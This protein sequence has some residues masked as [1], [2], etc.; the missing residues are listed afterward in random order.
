MGELQHVSRDLSVAEKISPFSA[1]ARAARTLVFEMEWQRVLRLLD[2][3]GIEN[4]LLKGAAFA[5]T[6]YSE[7]WHRQMGDIDVW[8]RTKNLSAAGQVL[9]ENGYEEI[10]ELTRPRELQIAY[11]GE[12]KFVRRAGPKILVELHGNLYSGMWPR[13]AASIDENGIWSRRVYCESGGFWHLDPYD[14]WIHVCVHSV[15]CH[16]LANRANAFKDLA[17]LRDAHSLDWELIAERARSWAVSR[18]VWLVTYAFHKTNERGAEANLLDILAPPPLVRRL[19][20]KLLSATGKVDAGKGN[21]V[22]SKCRYFLLLALIDSWKGRARIV[23]KAIWPG[24]RWLLLRNGYDGKEQSVVLLLE[25]LWKHW[26]R[27]L[28][29]ERF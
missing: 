3:A 17:A 12:L 21:M 13:L 16:Q 29:K 20:E 6:I 27:G 9:V 14:M 1:I 10:S 2:E 25:L 19:L 5:Q 23:G 26:F 28:L 18:A 11:D 8:V 4:V 7:P 24:R 22:R 15:I